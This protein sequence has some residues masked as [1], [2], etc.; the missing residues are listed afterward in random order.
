MCLYEPEDFPLYKL[1]SGTQR[2][3][4]RT[5]SHIVVGSRFQWDKLQAKISDAQPNFFPASQK[6]KS[7]FFRDCLKTARCYDIPP[8]RLAT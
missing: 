7:P 1:H 6:K 2:F 8:F 5:K 4:V 3:C